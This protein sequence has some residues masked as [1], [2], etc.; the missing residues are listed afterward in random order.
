VPG[1]K[2][3]GWLPEIGTTWLF[4]LM[5]LLATAGVSVYLI[6]HPTFGSWHSNWN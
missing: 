5:S 2:L 4:G 6:V 3:I 1:Q